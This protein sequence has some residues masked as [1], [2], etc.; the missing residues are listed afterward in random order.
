VGE[1]VVLAVHE[2]QLAE[3]GGPVGIRDHGLVQSALVRPQNLAAYGDPDAADLAACYAW[4]I[5]RNHGFVDGNK[6]TAFVV[7]YVFLL[8]NGYDLTAADQQAVTVMLSVANGLVT[9][10]DLATWFRVHIREA[11][12]T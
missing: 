3:H 11:S 1:S 12:A 4:G 6:R 7:A 5:S 2:Q 9:E 10:A 8:D